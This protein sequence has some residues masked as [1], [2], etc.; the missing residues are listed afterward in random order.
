MYTKL[1]T[2][3]GDVKNF[4]FIP[5]SV[6]AS[7]SRVQ[8]EGISAVQEFSRR[9]GCRFTLV[10]H[11]VSL[12]CEHI[13]QKAVRSVWSVATVRVFGLSEVLVGTTSFGF[14][15]GQNRLCTPS[16]SF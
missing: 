5:S 9:P 10:V 4:D 6:L 16:A 14:A 15:V 2:V 8:C 1:L 3:S 13:L 7:K 11:T 12:C